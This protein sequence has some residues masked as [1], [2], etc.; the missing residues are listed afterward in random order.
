[1]RGLRGSAGEGRSKVCPKILHFQ[2]WF[3]ACGCSLSIISALP[4]RLRNLGEAGHVFVC[5]F[6]G[7]DASSPGRRR[8]GCRAIATLTLG[9][10]TVS[11]SVLIVAIY[12]PNVTE[13]KLMINGR[14]PAVLL[15][16]MGIG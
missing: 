2:R 4:V 9:G 6:D 3:S 8:P 10:V 1:M 12:S 14:I 16:W 13:K 5:I 11:F 7:R 15:A